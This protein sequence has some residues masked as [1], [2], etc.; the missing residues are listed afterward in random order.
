MLNSLVSTFQ[1]AFREG[2]QAFEAMLIANEVV[3]SCTREGRVGLIWKLD[4]EKAYNHVSWECSLEIIERMGFKDR[5]RRWIHWCISTTSFSVLINGK[6]LGF[7]SSSRGLRQGDYL[8]LFLFI[9]I[10]ELL[11]RFL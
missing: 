9:L 8:S 2:K 11:R 5:W 7:F 4:M 1:H 10:M 6:A 3:D